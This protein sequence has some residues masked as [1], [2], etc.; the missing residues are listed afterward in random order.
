ML[1][2][3]ASQQALR[4]QEDSPGNTSNNGQRSAA[5]G[6]SSPG[7]KKSKSLAVKWG[8]DSSY[9]GGGPS[10]PG[11]AEGSSAGS[12]GSSPH[13][14]YSTTPSSPV[15]KRSNMWGEDPWEESHEQQQQQQSGAAAGWSENAVGSASGAQQGRALSA[16]GHSASTRSQAGSFSSRGTRA[17]D[18]D[19]SSGADA[20]AGFF[21]SEAASEAYPK[22]GNDRPGG[23]R[24]SSKAGS[25]NG[26]VG[27]YSR[28]SSRGGAAAAAVAAAGADAHLAFSV[29]CGVGSSAG[30]SC[31]SSSSGSNDGSS[32]VAEGLQ[33]QY[34][35]GVIANMRASVGSVAAAG[36]GGG[37]SEPVIYSTM[38]ELNL[39]E[40]PLGLSGAKAVAQVG[41]GRRLL[42]VLFL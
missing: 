11:G 3:R 12:R 6:G 7:Y 36:G 5:G 31:R 21:L 19:A 14:G 9:G 33:Q 2:P 29:A 22:A 35:A 23:S 39:S 42:G 25:G 38:S 27:S 30:S 32:C 41:G 34:T 8:Q 26:S 37:A 24:W 13:G 15:G 1:A 4:I 20:A 10:S 17:L 28:Q 18:A 16:R 40:N